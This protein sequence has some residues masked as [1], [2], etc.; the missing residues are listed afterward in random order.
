MLHKACAEMLG[1]YVHVQ[2]HGLLL[3][4]T[5]DGKRSCHAHREARGVAP[6]ATCPASFIE[7]VCTH[8][9][10]GMYVCMY[11]YAHKKNQAYI[12]KY[13]Y[14]SERHRYSKPVYTCKLV[15]LDD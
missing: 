14:R 6:A 2:S 7:Y 10:P 8:I 13:T 11:V 4:D 5:Y 12:R 9:Q 1:A 3:M 15:M